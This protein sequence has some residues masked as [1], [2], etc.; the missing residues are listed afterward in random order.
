MPHPRPLTIL[1]V[2]VCFAPG[3]HADWFAA[4]E[5]VNDL[6]HANGTPARRYHVRHR[7]L[8]GWLTR[9]FAYFL[10]DA[11][12]RFGAVTRAAGGRKS[13]LDLTGTAATA[14]QDAAQRWRAWNTHVAAITKPARPWEHYLAQHHAD[15]TK[16]SLAEARRR[17]EQQPHVLA[18][19]A[20]T[21]DPYELS[22]YQAGEATYSALYWRKALIGD[23]LITTDG[24]LLLPASDSIADRFRFLN[25][26]CTYL[27]SLRSNARLCAIAIA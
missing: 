9:W 18:M 23:A 11:A 7:P 17:F 8:L 20:H 25:A 15:P 10:L 3:E 2:T 12:R 1:V 6:L 27:R 14:A 16:V 21:L 13:R 19:L 5:K 22:V 26:A 24:Q 4:S